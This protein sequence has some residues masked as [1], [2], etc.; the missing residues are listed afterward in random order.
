[1]VGSRSRRLVV[2][3]KPRHA[4]RSAFNAEPVRN[5]SSCDAPKEWFSWSVSVLPS[6]CWTREVMGWWGA[7]VASPLIVIRVL[8]RESEK[9]L[10]LP[11]LRAYSG[12]QPRHRAKP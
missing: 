10:L 3:V 4:L 7:R 2:Q 12:T 11:S 9:P 8:K 1:M 6:A 5:Q